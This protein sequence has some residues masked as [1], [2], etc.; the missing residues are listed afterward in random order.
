MKVEIF[1]GMVAYRDYGDGKDNQICPREFAL[2]TDKL[3]EFLQKQ[4]AFGGNDAAEDVLGGLFAATKLN[5]S[6]KA[7]FLILIADS[8]GH[9]VELH[10]GFEDRYLLLLLSKEY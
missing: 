1:F 6:S 8:P 10:G 2:G 3:R 5:W 4:E 9:G 7:R